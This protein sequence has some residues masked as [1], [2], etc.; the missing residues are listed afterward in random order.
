MKNLF[1]RN[2]R[3]FFCNKL[4]V[5]PDIYRVG[6]RMHWHFI[7][8]KTQRDVHLSKVILIIF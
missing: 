1:L 8:V 3:I 6:M 4:Y 5:I 7:L 2:Q